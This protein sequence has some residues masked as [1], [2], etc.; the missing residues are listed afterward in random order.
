MMH[1]THRRGQQF[2]RALHLL[3]CISLTLSILALP[4][5]KASAQ[6]GDL[7][8]YGA[9]GY[10][11]NTIVEINL[12]QNSSRVV[13]N[14]LFGTQ[15]IEQD[16]VTGVVYYYEW[17]KTADEF[18]YW[19][20]ATGT[21]TE[22]T[23]Y[24]P[25][26]KIYAKRMAFHPD[27]TLYL[28]DNNDRL[29]TINPQTG[30]LTL[31]GKI[32]GLENGTLG[33]TG[34]MAFAPDG[35]LYVATYQ[36]L[37]SVNIPSRSATLLYS[38][39]IGG[40]GVV[41]WSGLAYCNGMLYGSSLEESVGGSNIYRINPQTGQTEFLFA[42]AAI[43]NDLTSCAATS[44]PPANQPPQAV[45][46]AYQTDAGAPLN[47]SAPGVLGND[48][49]PDND[50]LTAVLVSGP[51]NGQLNLSASGAFTYTP[52]P[53]F[54]G[55]DSF[56][57]QAF[58][59]ELSSNTATVTITVN[60][61]Q[62]TNQPPQ[63]V[64]DAYQ[65]DA[66]VPLNVSTPG[67]LGNDSDPDNDGLTAVLVS[68]PAN[69]QLNLS[70]SGA[71]T[72][73]P[74]PGFSGFDSFT[75]Q[76]FDGELSSNTATVTITVAPPAPVNQPPQ[77]VNDAYQTDA[78]TPLNVSAP[79]VLGND[80]DPDNDGLS[81]VLISG[82]ANGQLNL[83]TSGAFTYTPNPGFSG[84]DSFT[85]QAFDGELSSNTA[86]V[87]IT[88][89]PIAPPNQPPVAAA[90]AYSTSAG[91]PLVVAAPGVLDNDSD[92]DGDDLVAVLVTPPASGDLSFQADGGFTYTPN[93]GFSGIDSFTYRAWDGELA[94]PPVTVTIT[95]TP[96]S[97]PGDLI[98]FGAN[99]Y[100]LNEIYAINLTQQTS[101][102]V[103]E[104]AF[105]SLAIDVDPQSGYMYYFE[106]QRSATRFGYWD[107]VTGTHTLVRVYNPSP[108]VNFSRMAFHPNGTLFMMDDR[109]RLYLIDKVT[110]DITLLGATSGMASGEFRGTG[111]MA[112]AP[113]GTLYV[114]TNQHLYTLDV[115]TRQV[116]LIAADML[117]GHEV[118][119]WSGLAFCNGMLYGA[120]IHH[121]AG[122]DYSNLY[123]IDPI[124]G[125][126][127][128][129]FMNPNY[130]NDLTGCVSN[131]PF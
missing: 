69:G 105:G 43:L 80:S 89:N 102:L 60:P 109:D 67:V 106:W 50:G 3:L 41:V 84:V 131:Y 64:N 22:I 127:E 59:G 30:A 52:N 51:A 119:I 97:T 37:Y 82:P 123:R 72:Y 75:Y 20:P 24:I 65:T 23:V 76:A 116:T 58:D 108:K 122:V 40:S 28:M 120:D 114:A 45:N 26:P 126:T 113:D 110:G 124:T 42:S 47:V 53:G 49:D 95:V 9:N 117:S 35:T 8:I 130:V 115:I 100:N 73:T 29:Y 68:G 81:A 34:D 62:P 63:A 32:N 91:V 7:I 17:Q 83:S 12:T 66:G 39:M 96:V 88:V 27:G 90:D 56:T 54:S 129:L 98:V 33:A 87:T 101:S 103:G 74:N 99:A 104:L 85:Y 92:P 21:S 94:S 107:P 4:V 128:F 25:S 38:G 11:I 18:A 79:G 1:N 55:V 44:T 19:D 48:S 10:D 93:P 61:P 2:V 78:D 6:A 121:V 112:F 14:L 118:D 36:S 125:A 15:A 46:D 70:A 111:D 16:P 31:L 57:Y 77:A 71:F 13:G 86:T 5:S